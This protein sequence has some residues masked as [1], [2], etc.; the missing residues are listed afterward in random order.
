MSTLS[1]PVVAKR[2]PDPVDT[3]VG[4]RLRLARTARGLSQ[5]ALAADLG[6]S[7][8]QVQKYETGANRIGAS[9]LWSAARQLGVAVGY[10]FEGLDGDGE[11]SS[12]VTTV[13]PPATVDRAALTAALRLAA[14]DNADLKRAIEALIEALAAAKQK[15]PDGH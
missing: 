3:H 5:S 1:K 14:F 15:P 7:F 11:G 4:A 13:A 8:Q 12:T 6:I 9:R 10:F 2:M